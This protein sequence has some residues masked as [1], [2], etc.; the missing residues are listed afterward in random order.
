[1]DF[2]A[3]RTIIL[4]IHP[5]PSL[6]ACVK[7][8]SSWFKSMKHKIDHCHIDHRLTA[9]YQRFIIFAESTV[10]SEPT[11]CPL[12]D[13]AFGYNLKIMK[14]TPFNNLNDPIE[15]LLCPPHKE[16][17][18]TTIRPNQF[19]TRTTVAKPDQHQL[20]ARMILNICCMNDQSNNQA[21]RIDQDMALTTLYLLARVVA[22]MPPFKRLTLWLS[23]IA[24]LGVGLRPC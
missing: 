2:Y 17:T 3:F 24:A 10:F 7:R 18:I 22:T 13:P 8:L 20:A 23:R 6:R 16:T 21:K 14:V 15:L 1:V 19:Q 4:D 12:H 5:S 9:M 11:K